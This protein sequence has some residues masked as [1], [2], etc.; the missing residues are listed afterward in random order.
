[1]RSQDQA[2][3]NIIYLHLED[4]SRLE[5]VREKQYEKEQPKRLEESHERGW[6]Y[7][8][9]EVSQGGSGRL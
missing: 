5:S 3:W 7:K 9:W 2:L 6:C 8:N 1:M 4:K